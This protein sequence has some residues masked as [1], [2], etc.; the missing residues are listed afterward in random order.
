MVT[1]LVAMQTSIVVGKEL[2][3]EAASPLWNRL[4][5]KVLLTLTCCTLPIGVYRRLIFSHDAE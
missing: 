2:C 5:P 4:E 3:E 1:A